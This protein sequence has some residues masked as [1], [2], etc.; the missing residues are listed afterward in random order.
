AAG[1]AKGLVA[2]AQ[3]IEKHPALGAR[4]AEKSI[5]LWP[6]AEVFALADEALEQ[7]R[8]AALPKSIKSDDVASLIFTS[9][10]TGKPKGVMLSHR[11]L[12]S[13]VARLAEVFELSVKDGLLSVL[14]L[15]H[16]FEFSTGLLLPLSHGAQISYLPELTGDAIS[17]VL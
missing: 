12:T 4:L 8:V 14:P 15:H 3:Q 11:N 2:S 9:G 1:K 10:T 16:T 5:A 13:M 7:K 17:K 6:I